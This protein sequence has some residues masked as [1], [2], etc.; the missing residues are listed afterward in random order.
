MR[1]AH[2][3][4]HVTGSRFPRKVFSEGE[5]PDARFTLANERTFLA[6]TRTAL[7]LLAGAVA[8]H[9]PA[10]DLD[11]WV[12]VTASLLLIGAAG[13]AIGQSWRRWHQV[14]LAIRTGRPLPGFAGPAML[15]SVLGVL[16]AGVAIGIVV[17]AVR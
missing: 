17:V 3:G 9:T 1:P 5:E 8:V 16:I 10:V 7:A 2:Q 4:V 13:L 14:E 6:W 11:E 12:K 15:A